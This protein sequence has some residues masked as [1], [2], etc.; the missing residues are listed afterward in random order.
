MLVING[1]NFQFKKL[2]NKGTIK[3]WRFANRSCGVLLHTSLNEEFLRYSGKVTE[4]T[5][6]PNPAGVE[7]RNFRETMRQRAENELLTL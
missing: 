3:F 1:Y 2:N 6:L 7:I 4:H 5:H